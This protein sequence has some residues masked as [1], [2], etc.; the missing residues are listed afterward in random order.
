MSRDR[1]TERDRDTHSPASPKPLVGATVLS[2]KQYSQKI[3]NGSVTLLSRGIPPRLPPYAVVSTG[4]TQEDIT[5]EA[6]QSP[7]TIIKTKPGS[8]GAAAA[9]LGP[10]SLLSAAERLICTQDK[11]VT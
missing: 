7:K 6:Q 8:G 3:E 11:Q 10:L 4:Q 9:R 2:K 5:Q 1:D